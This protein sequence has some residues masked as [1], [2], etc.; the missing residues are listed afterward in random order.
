MGNAM[1]SVLSTGQSHQIF[2]GLVETKRRSQQIAN[3]P[4][5][6]KTR[7]LFGYFGHD[8]DV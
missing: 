8:I 7:L 2:F 3:A 6:A 4:E 1:Y 5:Q